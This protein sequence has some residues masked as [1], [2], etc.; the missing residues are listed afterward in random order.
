[1]ETTSPPT[2]SSR[3]GAPLSPIQTAIKTSQTRPKPPLPEHINGESP[4]NRVPLRAIP[5]PQ[6]SKS[7]LRN[8]FTRNKPSRRTSPGIDNTLPAIVESQKSVASS[9][10]ITRNP[11]SV[12]SCYTPTTVNSIHD[13]PPVPP[14]FSQIPKLSRPP[15]QKSKR[16]ITAWDPPPLFKAFPQ[17]IKHATLPSPTI[18]AE[19]VLRLSEHYRQRTATDK[20]AAAEGTASTD[21]PSSK[22]DARKKKEQK[23]AKSHSRRASDSLNKIEWTRKIYML[24]T[25]GYLLQY[26]G[27]GNFDRLPEKVMELGK[28][29]VAFACDAIPGKHWVLQISQTHEDKTAGS[30]EMKRNLLARLRFPESRRSAKSLLLVLN[31]AEEL[32]AWLSLVRREIEAAGGKEYTTEAPLQEPLNLHR[33]RSSNTIGSSH[34]QSIDSMEKSLPTPSSIRSSH[35]P[36]PRPRNED[37]VKQINRKSIRQSIEASSL[38]T[39]ATATDLDRLRDGSRLSYVSVGTR[40]MPSSR[41]SSPSPSTTTVRSPVAKRGYVGSPRSVASSSRDVQGDSYSRRT[42]IVSPAQSIKL[43]DVVNDTPRS[44]SI[45]NNPTRS[46]TPNFSLPMLN[47]RH[48]I[49]LASHPALPDRANG[50]QSPAI[51]AIPHELGNFESRLPPIARPRSSSLKAKTTATPI[52]RPFGSDGPISS[53]ASEAN[54]QSHIPTS[55]L[56]RIIP[57]AR[58][59]SSYDNGLGVNYPASTFQPNLSTLKDDDNISQRQTRSPKPAES[60][61]TTHQRP[62]SLQIASTGNSTTRIPR[63]SRP[64][65]QPVVKTPKDGSPAWTQTPPPAVS[66]GARTPKKPSTRV[67]SAQKSMPHLSLGPPTAPPPDCP[68]PE[69][70]SSIACQFPSPWARERK[71]SLKGT[72]II[73]P[74][75][76]KIAG[77]SSRSKRY[78]VVPAGEKEFHGRPKTSTDIHAKATMANAF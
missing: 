62:Q 3:R 43:D 10:T 34:K 57:R 16:T 28:N 1:M 33:Y 69:V 6:S 11:S 27:D 25:S 12:V 32:A 56:P 19:T 26:G 65:K 74:I 15:K 76:E 7:S 68:L 54:S 55:S 29:S 64:I 42:S 72:S 59:Y 5:R 67:L 46:P 53:V 40:T 2:I 24:V 61:P 58:R 39:M 37:L 51:P 13:P 41:A 17:A 66:G 44:R 20:E 73:T 70:P 45:S 78:P 52:H 71:S 36:S 60:N 75:P 22:L 38:S 63:S 8:L 35:I 21:K 49:S 30:T 48:S 47:K 50:G 14:T 18:S 23:R 9:P 77:L 4:A 31:N